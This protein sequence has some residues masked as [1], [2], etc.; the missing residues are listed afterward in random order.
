VGKEATH[1]TIEVAD[2]IT[3]E[4]TF[5]ISA[6]LQGSASQPLSNK[7]ISFDVYDGE[8]I[9]DVNRTTNSLGV[10]SADFS[11]NVVGEYVVKAEFQG[12]SDYLESYDITII[13]V[14][15]LATSLTLQ[16]VDEATLNEQLDLNALL[17]D[18]YE[19]PIHD[20][21]VE[22][23]LYNGSA[24]TLLGSSETDQGGVA[25]FN[26]VPTSAGN[27]SLKV[28]FNGAAKYAASMSNEHVLMVAAPQT[29]YMTIIVLVVIAAV[30]VALAFIVLRRRKTKQ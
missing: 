12:S 2:D 1:V 7:Q 5:T 27:F 20:A 22:F 29:D 26:Y 6:T 28:T 24:W 4:K 30:A 13:M 15:P 10:A 17:L 16:P 21:T 14:D 3:V 9:L 8:I 18:A 19:N 23:H 11:L 25:S